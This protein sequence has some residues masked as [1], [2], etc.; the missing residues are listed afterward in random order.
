MSDNYIFTDNIINDPSKNWIVSKELIKR[1]KLSPQDHENMGYSITISGEDGNQYDW[2]Y[3]LK[4][5]MDWVEERGLTN[6]TG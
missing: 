5:H 1:L 2:C 4:R 6:A 3:I